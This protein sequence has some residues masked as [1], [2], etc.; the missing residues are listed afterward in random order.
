MGD[1]SKRMSRSDA[2]DGDRGHYR[3]WEIKMGLGAPRNSEF[4]RHCAKGKE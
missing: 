3:W 2:M 1:E 4:D